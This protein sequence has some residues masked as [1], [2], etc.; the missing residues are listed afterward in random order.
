MAWRCLPNLHRCYL[1]QDLPCCALWGATWTGAFYFAHLLPGAQKGRT[2]R[3][4]T[5]CCAAS[6]ESGAPSHRR[7]A[8]TE[9][10]RLQPLCNVTVRHQNALAHLRPSLH[11]PRPQ[12]K[13]LWYEREPQPWSFTRSCETH[14]SRVACPVVSVNDVPEALQPATPS[15]VCARGRTVQAQE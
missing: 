12:R 8:G 6:W 14:S 5:S 9:Q 10:H 15:Q 11:F 13:L 1:R 4:A 2:G 7:V 3:R